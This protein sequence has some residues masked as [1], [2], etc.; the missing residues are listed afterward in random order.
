MIHK[1]LQ[2]VRCVWVALKIIRKNGGE[3]ICVGAMKTK[4][5]PL[6]VNRFSFVK[7]ISSIPI[8]IA[9]LLLMGCIFVGPDYVS[10]NVSGH[11]QWSYALEDGLI[12]EAAEF[13]T[14]S[15]W[16]STLKDPV[17]THHIDLADEGNLDLDEATASVLE[18]RAGRGI[19]WAARLLALV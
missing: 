4:T 5:L 1:Y 13:Q 3:K 8:V 15:S 2:I 7:D 16:W 17:L 14:Q 6:P 18:A 19:S 12:R 10:P 9:I 11:K